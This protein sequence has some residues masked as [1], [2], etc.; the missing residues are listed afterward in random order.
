MLR[1]I[2]DWDDAYANMANIPDGASYPDRWIPRAEAF[3]AEL[4]AAGRARL[5]VPHGDHPRDRHDLFLPDGPPRGIVVFIHGGYWMRFDRTLW[6]HLAAG[7]LAHGLA[8]AM[9]SYPLCPHIRLGA[10]AR[11][12]ARTVETVTAS[13]VGPVMLAGHSAGGHLATRLVTGTTPLAK[14]ALARVRRV[15]SISGVHDLRP[16]LATEMN[17]TLKLDEEEAAAESPALLTPVTGTTL[18]AWAGG[19][20][21]AEFLRQNALI[22]STWLGLGARTQAVEE[23]D[24]HHF[25]IIDGLESADHPLTRALV[26]ED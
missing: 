17:A 5:D 26:A 22:A 1:K 6:S 24:R 19:G 15:V 14:A 2:T 16:L 13:V 23:P 9:P 12:V 20:E 7:P 3:R 10:I 4:A 25:N 21:R 18:V 11:H 8:V